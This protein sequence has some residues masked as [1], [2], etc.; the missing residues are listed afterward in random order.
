MDFG[1]NIGLKTLMMFDKIRFNLVDFVFSTYP[2]NLTLFNSRHYDTPV[3][4]YTKAKEPSILQ[5]L[6]LI[7]VEITKLVLYPTAP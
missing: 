4:K 7:A 1:C 3:F 6:G 2:Q 5:T